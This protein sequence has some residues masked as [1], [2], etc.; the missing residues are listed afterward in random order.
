MAKLQYTKPFYYVVSA[1][2]RKKKNPLS[3]YEWKEM[4]VCSTKKEA[5]DYAKRE[6]KIKYSDGRTGR[7]IVQKVINDSMYL[8]GK[9][10][11]N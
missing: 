5:T 4:R 10:Q 11:E 3:T 8:D 7:Y 2:F 6:S 1:L 9:K